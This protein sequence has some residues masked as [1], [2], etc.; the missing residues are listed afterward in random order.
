MMVLIVLNIFLI[1]FVW[2]NSLIA[3]I[4]SVNVRALMSSASKRP[5]DA[6]AYFRI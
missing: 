1:I 4:S 6:L 3:E 2:Y 5:T